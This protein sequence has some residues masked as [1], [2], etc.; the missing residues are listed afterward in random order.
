MKKVAVAIGKADIE[1]AHR[2]GPTSSTNPRPI[3]V[4][5]FDRKK[6]DEILRNRHKLKGEGVVIGEDLTPATY[7]IHIDA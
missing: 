1:V 4:R 2:P 7:K 5:F 3:L 6:P